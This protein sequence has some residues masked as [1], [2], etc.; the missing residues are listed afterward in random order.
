MEEI[1]FIER[2]DDYGDHA[3]VGFNDSAQID[4]IDGEAAL[5]GLQPE[6]AMERLTTGLMKGSRR[7]VTLMARGSC[8]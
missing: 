3:I 4:L 1:S 6:P 5:A 2:V 8:G 7:P